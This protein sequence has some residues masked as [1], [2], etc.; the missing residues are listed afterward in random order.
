MTLIVEDGSGVT[1]ANSYVTLV[2]A[3]AY[4]LTRGVEMT[5][6][7]SKLEMYLVKA[8]DYL[9]SLRY[10]FKGRK[11]N[12]DQALQWPRYCV[13]IDGYAISSEAIPTE[14]KNAQMQIAMAIQSGI[15]FMPTA[16]GEAFVISEK[17]GPIETKYSEGV[18]TSGVPIVRTVEA[19]LAPLMNIGFGLV[20][21]RA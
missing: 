20:T 12:A 11:T 4:A 16:S 13:Y 6:V 1:G 21:E 15:D 3:R 7:D 19:L 18:S 10:G 14:L 17:V 8:M 5:D 2:E 9:E